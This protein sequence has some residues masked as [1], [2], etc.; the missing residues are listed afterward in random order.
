M[1][2][3]KS[4]TLLP[5][6]ALAV[7][8]FAF[9]DAISLKRAI[10]PNTKSTYTVTSTVKQGFEMPGGGGQQD[11][12]IDT[13]FVYTLEYGDAD[14]QTGKTKVTARTTEISM[15]M[16]G[17]MSGM[18]PQNEMPKEL[19]QEGTVDSQN[20][21]VL[22]PIKNATPAVMMMSQS[23][24][25][26]GM[27]LFHELPNNA[28]KVGDTWEISLPASPMF[29]NKE[30]KMLG[31]LVEEKD[32]NGRRV[33]VF[34]VTGNL[35]LDMDMSEMMKDNPN[36]PAGMKMQMKGSVATTTTSVV[37]KATGQFLSLE[38]K[39]SGKQSIEMVDMGMSIP[40]TSEGITKV[41]L[42]G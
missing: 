11:M 21:I 33:V 40:V 41:A 36:A 1:K 9:Q 37:D 24:G 13:G 38:S 22:G 6:A 19:V 7:V 16:D 20:R 35:N 5:L 25:Q 27:G 30:Q 15:K 8:G 12:T 31:K 4:L 17:P 10:Q 42:K 2:R 39:Y 14:A 34:E 26:G 18:M 3:M 29:G 23:L 32:W 28:L